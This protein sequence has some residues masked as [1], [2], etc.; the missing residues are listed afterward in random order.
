MFL[1]KHKCIAGIDAAVLVSQAK[2]QR[3]WIDIT[4][5]L[6][7]NYSLALKL[8]L[9]VPPIYNRLRA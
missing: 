4:M 1:D 5:F 6:R 2:K 9:S 7:L 8:T 3:A